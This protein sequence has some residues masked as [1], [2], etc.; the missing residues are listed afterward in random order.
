M[1]HGVTKAAKNTKNKG[2]QHLSAGLIVQA[3]SP[4]EVV[5]LAPDIARDLVEVMQEAP[6]EAP[7]PPSRQA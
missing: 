1:D 4:E 3:D 7:A 5:R 6:V 2:V